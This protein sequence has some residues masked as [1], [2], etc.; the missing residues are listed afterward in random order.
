M[1]KGLIIFVALIILA[2]LGW[3]LLSPLFIVVELEQA[4][5]FDDSFDAMSAEEKQEFASA[6]DA[7]KDDVMVM[8]DTMPSMGASDTSSTMSRSRATSC[9]SSIA[10]SE[11]SLGE[12]LHGL[13]R[14]A[15]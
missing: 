9:A 5:P 13:S 6:V 10:S 2:G 8:S 7:M 4:S 14:T 15:A 11:S 12:G 3:Y 1:K